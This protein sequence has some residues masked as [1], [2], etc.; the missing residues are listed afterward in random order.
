[1]LVAACLLELDVFLKN[2]EMIQIRQATYDRALSSMGAN[3][4]AREQD[5]SQGGAVQ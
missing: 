3:D 2:Q 4:T 5:D 1:V